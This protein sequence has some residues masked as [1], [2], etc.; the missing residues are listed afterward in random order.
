MIDRSELEQ[1][2][3]GWA[4]EYGGSR[5]EHVGWHSRNLLQTLVEHR[6]FVPSSRGYVPVPMHSAADEVERIVNEMAESDM[7]RH[8]NVLRCDY[9][10]PHLPITER[11]KRFQLSRA[12]YYAVLAEAKCYVRAALSKPAERNVA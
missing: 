12:R 5:Y 6:G 11:V 7:R 10:H 4:Q 9:F 2:L 1:R 8:A 3:T